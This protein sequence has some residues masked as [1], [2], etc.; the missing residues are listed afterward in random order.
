MRRQIMDSTMRGDALL[1]S[2][3]LRHGTTVDAGQTVATATTGGYRET[4]YAS[5]GQSLSR[6]A[7]GL[8]DLGVTG[9]QRV[10][11]F[12]WNNQ[13]HLEAYFAVPSMGAVLHTLNI[14]LALKHVAHIVNEAQDQIVMVDLSLAP[15]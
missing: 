13:E 2:K 6:L 5:L 15:Q 8:R 10:A 12:M 1:V 9:D 4:T 11:T 7:H 14:R 3:I